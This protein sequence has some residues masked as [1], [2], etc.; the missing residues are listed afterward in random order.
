[1]IV[2]IVF[3]FDGFCFGTNVFVMQCELFMQAI[4]WGRRWKYF[5]VVGRYWYL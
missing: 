3:G 5:N 1:L 2:L 4:I